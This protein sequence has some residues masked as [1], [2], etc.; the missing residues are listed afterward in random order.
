MACFTFVFVFFCVIDVNQD[1][2]TRVADEFV[3]LGN[4]AL[5]KCGVPSFAADFIDLIGWVTNEGYSIGRNKNG[6]MRDGENQLIMMAY[7][8]L[9]FQVDACA[10]FYLCF[11]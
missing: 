5:L 8:T 2:E 1:F 10:L 7:A 3:I 4:D 9:F 11:V 6:K